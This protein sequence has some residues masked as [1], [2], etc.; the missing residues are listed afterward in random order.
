M[1]LEL[2]LKSQIIS[3]CDKLIERYHAYH[4]HLHL[5][6]VRNT[7]R[8]A[9]A[10]E[11]TIKSPEYW[12]IDKKF[13]PF[14]VKRNATAIAKSIS[15]RITS[16]TYEP[17]PPHIKKIPKI[18]GGER[19]LTVYQIPDAAVSTYFYFRLL[20][21]NKHRFSSFSYAYRNDRNVH[22]AIQDIAVDLAHNARTFISEFDFSDFFRLYRS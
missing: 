3:E 17:F 5:E 7:K 2:Q 14:Y 12:D 10:P 15:K 16:G 20:S 1:S 18:G 4:N 11:K 22:F 9:G 8:I 6:W 13:N 21:K 19:E